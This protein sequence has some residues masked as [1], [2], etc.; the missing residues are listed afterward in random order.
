M[1]HFLCLMFCIPLYFCATAQEQTGEAVKSKKFFAG[2]TYTYL[3]ADMKL[4]SMTLHS[5][6]FGQ[7]LGE[8]KLSGEELDELN[9][10]FKRHS[11]IN[12]LLAEFGWRI[13]N[14]PDVKWNFTASIL[15]GIADNLSTIENKNTGTQEFKFNSGL[16]KPCL[17][18]AFDLGYRI[19]SHWGISL[20]PNIVGSMGKSTSVSDAI[21]PDPVN[22]TS[23]REHKYR[24]LYGKVSLLARFV[25]GPVTIYAG[26]GFYAFWSWHD[27]TRHYY[28]GQPG[29]EI[30]EEIKTGAVTRS[31]FAG[32]VGASWDII[33]QLTLFAQSEI[34]NDLSV[35]GGVHFNF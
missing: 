2:V 1:K 25:T 26:P 29:E 6:W 22:F 35:T 28:E 12:A 19:T 34:G 13:V 30:I 11:N 33:P 17:G 21:Y 23:T 14:K 32:A 15:A 31:L 8:T 4:A 16:S 27:Y 3:S 24:N 9:N 20:Q 10:D 18:L 5:V 7:D